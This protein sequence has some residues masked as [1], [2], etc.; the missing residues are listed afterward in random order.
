MGMSKVGNPIRPKGNASLRAFLFPPC[1]GRGQ[2]VPAT[3]HGRFTAPV[4]V[5]GGD[6]Q[7]S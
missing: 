6:S 5:Q 3:F 7:K 1:A 4:R 2:G